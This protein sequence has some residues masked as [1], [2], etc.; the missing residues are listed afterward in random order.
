[1]PGFGHHSTLLRESELVSNVCSMNR[2]FP[3]DYVVTGIQKM[4]LK[5][6]AIFWWQRGT[7]REGGQLS[8]GLAGSSCGAGLTSTFLPFFPAPLPAYTPFLL[9]PRTL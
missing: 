9:S 5:G 4:S 7:G 8:S 3:I 1:M 2:T 6:Y